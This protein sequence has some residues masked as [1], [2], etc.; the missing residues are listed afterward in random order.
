MITNISAD[1]MVIHRFHLGL[2]PRSLY[3]LHHPLQNFNDFV[4]VI[5]LQF[6]LC[7][8]YD[9]NMKEFQAKVLSQISYLLKDLLD[10]T[11]LIAHGV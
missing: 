5:V 6:F 3:F 4:V 9:V 10:I 1:A 7:N 11:T 2:Y 8:R